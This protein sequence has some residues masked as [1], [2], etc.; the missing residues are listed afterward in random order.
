MR[1]AAASCSQR[2][3]CDTKRD[4][5]GRASLA[6][7]MQ[8][9][10]PKVRTVLLALIW[11]A[12]VGGAVALAVTRREEYGV[13]DAPI[14]VGIA[15]FMLI[16]FV[17]SFLPKKLQGKSLPDLLG[18]L[19]VGALILFAIA[20][21]SYAIIKGPRGILAT[22]ILVLFLASFVRIFINYLKNIGKSKGK[23]R[24]EERI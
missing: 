18:K 3:S 21:L 16:I 15:V 17:I 5:R 10:R 24:S 1:A 12:V 22:G 20:V 13:S 8:T 7:L 19:S 11:L 4:V 23:K 9:A 2:E 14:T 6:R